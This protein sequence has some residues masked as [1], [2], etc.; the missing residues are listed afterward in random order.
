MSTERYVAEWTKAH[1][2]H[3]SFSAFTISQMSRKHIL[4]CVSR[5]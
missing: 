5:A 1:D 4:H 3:S 2:T